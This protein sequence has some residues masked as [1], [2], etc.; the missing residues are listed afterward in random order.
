ML[1]LIW[2]FFSAAILASIFFR[3]IRIISSLL[4]CKDAC[5]SSRLELQALPFFDSSSACS[6]ISSLSFRL[7]RVIKSGCFG[8]LGCLVAEAALPLADAALGAG[9]GWKVTGGCQTRVSHRWKS[10]KWW[11]MGCILPSPVDQLRFSP[12]YSECCLHF[13]ANPTG[14]SVSQ[15][16]GTSAVSSPPRLLSIE[17]V[18]LVI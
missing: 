7:Y 17:W 8:L 14:Y 9:G 16:A 6:T 3:A 13:A 5:R 2:V 18:P 15:L 4:R 12:L 10:V 11:E 1:Q